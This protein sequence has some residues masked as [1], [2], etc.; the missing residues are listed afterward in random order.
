MNSGVVLGLGISIIVLLWL[1]PNV[2]MKL[3]EFSTEGYK[4]ER[5]GR[6]VYEI[7][8]TGSYVSSGTSYRLANTS[9]LSETAS[10][11]LQEWFIR[12]Q[13]PT[14]ERKFYACDM[15]LQGEEQCQSTRVS[16]V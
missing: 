14:S 12:E 3:R 7:R 15:W 2:F 10:Q 13:I 4:G 1:I 11:I 16:G 9:R 6:Y 8:R 5:W